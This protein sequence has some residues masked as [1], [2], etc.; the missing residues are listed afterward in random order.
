MTGLKKTFHESCLI[1]VKCSFIPLFSVN[2][3][4]TEQRVIKRS[5]GL[6]HCGNIITFIDLSFQPDTAYSH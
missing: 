3:V 5:A 2:T 1:R 6:I 4:F